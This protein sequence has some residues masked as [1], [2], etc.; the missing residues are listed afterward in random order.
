MNKRISFYKSA[1]VLKTLC[2]S[3][4]EESIWRYS[5]VGLEDTI[6]QYDFGGESLVPAIS[7]LTLFSL[8]D[9]NGD[10]CLLAG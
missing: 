1:K 10:R 4:Q 9:A 7:L 3:F 8:M 5:S 6:H 2:L